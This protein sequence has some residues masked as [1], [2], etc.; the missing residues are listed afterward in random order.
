LSSD[1]NM[2]RIDFRP[3]T[4]TEQHEC[5]TYR[6]GD[7]VVFQCPHCPDY[8]RRINWRTGQSKVENIKPDI[9]HWGNYFPEEYRDAFENFN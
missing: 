2:R 6:V 7:W 9:T 4:D 3:P 5:S 8:K 1:E